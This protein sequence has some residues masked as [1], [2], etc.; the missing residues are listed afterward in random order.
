[1]GAAGTIG[2]PGVQNSKGEVLVVAGFMT[3][4]SLNRYLT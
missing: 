4:P 1:M 3:G 2:V